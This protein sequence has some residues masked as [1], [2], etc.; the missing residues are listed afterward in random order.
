MQLPVSF[1]E[2]RLEFWRQLWRVLDMSDVVIMIVD[3]RCALG[4]GEKGRLMT[5]VDA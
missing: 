3:A 5:S 1:Y 2:P 4:R